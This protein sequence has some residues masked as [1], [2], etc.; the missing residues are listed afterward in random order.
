MFNDDFM[1]YSVFKSVVL[2]VYVTCLGI[3]DSFDG[4]ILWQLF[5]LESVSFLCI[6]MGLAVMIVTVYCV[7]S[8]I[9]SATNDLSRRKT[10]LSIIV[11]V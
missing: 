8:H 4:L 5:E 2:S 6:A 3:S 11:D 9:N 1:N 10:V 7:A